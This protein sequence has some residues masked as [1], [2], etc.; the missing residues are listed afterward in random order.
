M[1]GEREA[2]VP[3]RER[4]MGSVLLQQQMSVQRTRSSQPNGRAAPRSSAAEAP[5][6]DDTDPDAVPGSVSADV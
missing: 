4:T 1:H 6:I 5:D 3:R 2:E